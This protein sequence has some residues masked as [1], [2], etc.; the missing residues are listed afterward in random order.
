MPHT[1]D[2]KAG[3]GIVLEFQNGSGYPLIDL[4]AAID[5]NQKTIN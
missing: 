5:Y 1:I 2:K 4:A 3:I